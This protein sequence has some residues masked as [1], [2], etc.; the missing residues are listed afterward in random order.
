MEIEKCVIQIT[1]EREFDD[2]SKICLANDLKWCD[3]DDTYN[4]VDSE[5][6]IIIVCD[7]GTS[8]LYD[9]GTGSGYTVKTRVSYSEFMD[10]Y[11][12]IEVDNIEIEKNKVAISSEKEFNDVSK[13]CL[14]NGFT[15]SDSDDAY[16]KIHGNNKGILIMNGDK[17]TLYVK[18]KE[19][20]EY[21][22]ISYS[23]FMSKYGKNNTSE[24]KK[25]KIDRC[26]VMITSEEDFD[27]VSRICLANGGKWIDGDD[28]YGS[29]VC[30]YKTIDI[31]SDG[32]MTYDSRVDYDDDDLISCDEFMR[33]YGNKQEIKVNKMK[34]ENCRI[35]ITSKEEFRK[36]EDV[37]FKNDIGWSAAGKSH[38][39]FYNGRDLL[40]SI[41]V[42]CT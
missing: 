7:D 24:V 4:S 9:T 15:W 27:K 8:I 25:M 5:K 34:I 13:I 17:D 28:T 23:T 32:D 3:S 11:G 41:S 12:K 29:M 1:S 30:T 2:V 19:C 39:D 14:D 21:D 16:N 10:K 36:V 37:C 38:H 33:K 20:Y 22:E 42:L 40:I 18:D 35:K 26:E 6:R 31:D